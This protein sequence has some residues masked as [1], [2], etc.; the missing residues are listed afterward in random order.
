M[1]TLGERKECPMTQV[2]TH[3]YELERFHLGMINEDFSSSKQFTPTQVQ[4][5]IAAIE[6]LLPTCLASLPDPW[7][8]E[9]LDFW[10]NCFK[11]ETVEHDGGTQKTDR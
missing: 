1:A 5:K 4:E 11:T 3:L 6:L 7:S 10:S 9:T 2:S 8:A